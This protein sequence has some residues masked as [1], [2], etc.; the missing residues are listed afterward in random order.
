VQR[1]FEMY[2]RENLGLKAIAERL[3]AEGIPSPRDG[4]WSE[5]TGRG[6][7][8]ATLQS[9]LK[10]RLYTGE[11]VWN[12]RA[13]GRFHSVRGREAA[14]RPRREFE[15]VKVNSPSDLIVVP[16]AHP[17]IIDQATFDEAQRLMAERGRKHVAGGVLRF[18]RAKNSPYLLSGVM[19]CAR[20]GHAFQGYSSHSRKHRKTGEKILTRYYACGGYVNKGNA[21]C[22]RTLVSMKQ[23][24]GYVLERMNLRVREL[25]ADGGKRKLRDA[26]AKELRSCGPDPK[27]E[28]R[29]TEA[30]L[31]SID[32][33]INRLLDSLT[34]VNKEFVDKKLV[35]LG[36]EQKELQEELKQSEVVPEGQIN[37]D[38][39]AEQ[40]VTG[41]V[42]FE[43]L[44]GQGT[45]EERKELVRAF[46][47]KLVIDPDAG[48][49]V[50]YIRQFP[51]S[52]A[53]TGK[54][55]F[56]MV[57]GAGFEPAT[58]GL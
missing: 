42:G 48:K 47:E 10:N 5:R 54:A 29:R 1:I 11:M 31:K 13:T 25:L 50:L 34:P 57:A 35:G 52:F 16:N 49:G 53:E 8:I 36:S 19:K 33:D 40:I 32:A 12:R 21:V 2:V 58:F 17:A 14:E 55:S 7:G 9:I 51:A 6:W 26:I 3:N 37:P 22:E 27:E 46:V 30:R 24:E 56:N 44:L 4:N 41:L 43:E 45:P 18:G 15:K 23:V 20:C 28:R 39:L 38:E